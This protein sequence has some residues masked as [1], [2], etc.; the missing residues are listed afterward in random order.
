[1]VVQ[2][3]ARRGNGLHISDGVFGGLAAPGPPPPAFGLPVRRIGAASAAPEAAFRVFGPTCDGSDVLSGELCLPADIA[4]GDWIEI[5]QHGAY[6]ACLRSDFNGLLPA[7][8]TT[9]ADG[10][11]LHTPGFPD[12]DI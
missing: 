3:L 6:G 2:V 9:V 10:P 5:G 12:H 8:T 4:E 7:L 1:M 11:M